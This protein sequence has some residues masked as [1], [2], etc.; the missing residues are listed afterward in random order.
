MPTKAE[1]IKDEKGGTKVCVFRG[2][3]ADRKEPQKPEHSDTLYTKTQRSHG[4][5]ERVKSQVRANE[6]ATRCRGDKAVHWELGLDD[7]LD[8]PG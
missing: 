2:G 3:G 6:V 1:K 5:Q 4:I 7:L 8:H